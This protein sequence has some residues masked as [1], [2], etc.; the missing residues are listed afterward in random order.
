MARLGDLHEAAMHMQLIEVHGAAVASRLA[1]L[2]EQFAAVASP[3]A[4]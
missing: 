1:T 2:R 3:G 4:S